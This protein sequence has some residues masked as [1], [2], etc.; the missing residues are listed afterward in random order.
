L[1]KSTE[2]VPPGEM[3]IVFGTEATLDT[4]DY[5]YLIVFNTQGNNNEPYALGANSNYDNWSFIIQVGGANPGFNAGVSAVSGPRLYEIYT[6]PSISVGYGTF[7]IN[8]PTGALVVRP[9]TSG[10]L[11]T[12]G[13]EVEFNRCLLDQP[14]PLLKPQPSPNPGA[15]CPPYSFIQ[16]SW[17][18]NVFTVDNTGTVVDSLDNN[19]PSGTTVQFVVN[20]A[21]AQ[22]PYDSKT[23]IT[24][25]SNPAAEIAGIQ[26]FTQPGPPTAATPTP[27]PTPTA[28]P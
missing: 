7:N 15:D 26:V 3:E 20:T 13:F 17:A 25:L 6:D 5:S 9:Y 27:T 24:Q 4:N 23:V 18:I 14:N 11:F 19:G 21:L 10:G 22:S 12:Q 28:S 2:L 1:G 8:Y 16:P